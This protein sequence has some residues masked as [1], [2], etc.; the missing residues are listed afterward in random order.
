MERNRRGKRMDTSN[1]SKKHTYESLL[2]W[3]KES[4]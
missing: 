4:Y 3:K 1:P 2:E